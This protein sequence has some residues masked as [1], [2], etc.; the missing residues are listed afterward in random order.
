MLT[1]MYC[2]HEGTYQRMLLR[3]EREREQRAHQRARSIAVQTGF[4]GGRRCDADGGELGD[5]LGEV[6]GKSGLP[7][8]SSRQLIRARRRGGQERAPAKR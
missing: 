3:R 4:D 7:C 1:W 2:V 6:R 8:R 5:E